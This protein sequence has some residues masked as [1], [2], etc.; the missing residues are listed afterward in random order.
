MVAIV[1]PLGEY[2]QGRFLIS[3]TISK[4][5][6]RNSMQ[7]ITGVGC[8]CGVLEILSGKKSITPKKESLPT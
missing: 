3:A 8:I 5:S 1:T 7:P 4:S 6:K 2:A